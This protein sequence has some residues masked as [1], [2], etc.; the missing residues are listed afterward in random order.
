MQCKN[1]PEI[2]ENVSN[3]SRCSQPFCPD[4]VITLKGLVYCADCKGEQI[5]DMQSGADSTTIE[6]ASIGKRFAANFIDGFVLM[7]PIFG[8]MAVLYV[9]FGLEGLSGQSGLLVAIIV[10]LVLALP[11]FLYEGIMLQL[12]QG[13]TVGKKAMKIKVVTAECTDISTAQSWKRAGMRQFLAVLAGH[14]FF[15]TMFLDYVFV[16]GKERA[17]LH[18]SYAKTRVINW[19]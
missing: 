4:C 2:E 7:I 11:T 18:D 17:C 1:H 13:Q 10:Q 12:C 9:M 3:C 5:K 15:L 14:T 19:Q 6:L 16:F 8:L